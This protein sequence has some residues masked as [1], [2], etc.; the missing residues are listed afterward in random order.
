MHIY[1]LDM[2]YKQ[3]VV[4]LARIIKERYGHVAD[5]RDAGQTIELHFPTLV[6][7]YHYLYIKHFVD[8]WLNAIEYNA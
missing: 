1:T 3:Y 7:H 6:N 4:P 8:G 5:V 2:K